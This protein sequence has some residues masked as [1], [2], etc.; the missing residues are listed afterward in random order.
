AVDEIVNPQTGEARKTV[1]LD[2]ER[3]FACFKFM[4]TE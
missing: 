2:R 1:E 4:T 3:L